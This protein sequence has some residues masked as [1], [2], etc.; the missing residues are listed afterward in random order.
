MGKETRK[1][2]DTIE[3]FLGRKVREDKKKTEKKSKK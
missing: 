2:S 3:E 1:L